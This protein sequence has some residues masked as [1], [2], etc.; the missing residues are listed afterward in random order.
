MREFLASLAGEPLRC[1]AWLALIVLA[2]LCAGAT[3]AATA[4]SPPAIPNSRCEGCHDDPALKD[5]A[6]HSLNVAATLF[7][8]SA[9]GKL[10]CV[11]CHQD[12]QSVRHPRENLSPVALTTCAGCHQDEIDSFKSSVHGAKDISPATCAG[13]HGDPHAV[14][15]RQ[16]PNNSM[17]AINQVRNC[18]HCHQD[19]MQGYLSSEHARALFALGLVSAPACTDCHGGGHD[20]QSPAVAAAGHR[21][22]DGG[23]HEFFGSC[24]CETGQRVC[25]DPSAVPAA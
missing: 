5:A 1:S 25:S 8:T 10:T 20:I 21:Y 6:G 23:R 16:D 13:C 15:R 12:A 9:H 3:R 19:M 11:D 24:P 2:T 17:S 14:L 4:S 7:A 18:G 22:A